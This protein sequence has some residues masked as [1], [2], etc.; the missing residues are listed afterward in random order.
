MPKRTSNRAKTQTS[1]L[2]RKLGASPSRPV[3]SDQMN[4][5][6][7]G[8]QTKFNSMNISNF[9]TGG[10]STSRSGN[11]GNQSSV[12][13]IAGKKVGTATQIP[14][15]ATT[16]LQSKGNDSLMNSLAKLFSFMQKS[17]EDDIKRRDTEKAFAEERMTE[18]QR[19]HDQFLKVLKD[20][21][22]V[23]VI[24]AVQEK[25]SSG[26]FFD[27]LWNT[28]KS[29]ISSAIGDVMKTI[30]EL[31]SLI[32]PLLQIAEQLGKFVGSNLFA[33]LTSG[34]GILGVTTF[35]A[36][37]ALLFL[38]K[39]EKE[40][41]E[42]NPND[43]KYKDNP[44]AMKLRGEATTIGQA[45]VVNQNKALKQFPRR[46]VEE[47]VKSNFSDA[48]L[49]QELGAD[50]PT[51]QKW[52]N[53][54]PNQGAMYQAPV[55][56]IAGQPQTAIPAGGLPQAGA[57]GGTTPTSG[58]VTPSSG[59]GGGGVPGATNPEMMTPSSSS[60]TSVSPTPSTSSVND[61]ISR[62]VDLSFNDYAPSGSG[63]TQPIVSSSSKTT[64]SPD[65]AMSSS[66]TQRDDT[67]ILNMIFNRSRAGV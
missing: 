31:K 27:G 33:L 59:G 56:A 16:G 63:A 58:S 10:S 65:K 43:P 53:D 8:F 67:A 41:I 60:A 9:I 39:A 54:N 40:A 14:K 50:R 42:A 66:A 46:T 6:A 49:I 34:A 45:T 29:M 28:I 30:L 51:L 32:T 18:E 48:E 20:F 22:D 24:T 11:Y 62:N 21:T 36:L 64:S 37:A 23:K 2:V 47:F 13:S 44:Y 7:S 55:A 4:S 17:R 26:G 12:H 61:A 3:A 38:A 15:L 1:N 25:E 5:Q 57:A 19:R 35:G 52:L